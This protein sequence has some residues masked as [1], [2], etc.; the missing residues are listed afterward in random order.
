M[1]TRDRKRTRRA[2]LVAATT[3]CLGLGMVASPV[4]E[5]GPLRTKLLQIL[6]RVRENHDLRP[7]RLNLRLSEDA[8]AHT[9]KMIRRGELFDPPNLADLLDPYRW[10]DIGADAVGCRDTLNRMVRQ[11]MSEGFHRRIILHP[12]LRRT[13]IG[14]IRVDGK[15]ACGRDQV[16]ATAIMYG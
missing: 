3:A 16:W 8:K 12:D 10:D 2:I 9:R 1:Q 7:L 15:S 4:A 14:V 11:W 5:A 13:G 6:N